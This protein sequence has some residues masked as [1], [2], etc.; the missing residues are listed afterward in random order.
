MT[1]SRT[2]QEWW[3]VANGYMV[4]KRPRNG[5]GFFRMLKL[6][7][8]FVT[9]MSMSAYAQIDAETGRIQISFIKAAGEGNGNLFF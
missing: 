5:R 1:K 7:M 4:A 9:V 6:V 3:K 2:R 8:A